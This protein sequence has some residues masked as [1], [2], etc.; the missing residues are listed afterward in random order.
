MRLTREQER[1]LR[2]LYKY[3]KGVTLDDLAAVTIRRTGSRLPDFE[4]RDRDLDARSAALAFSRGKFYV[5]SA[6]RYAELSDGLDLRIQELERFAREATAQTDSTDL[7]R[8]LV[9]HEQYLIEREV[10]WH[11]Y[12]ASLQQAILLVGNG[13]SLLGVTL[14]FED[15]EFASNVNIARNSFEHRNKAILKPS[16][17]DWSDFSELTSGGLYQFGYRKDASGLLQFRNPTTEGTV[18]IAVGES[19]F[20]VYQRAVSKAYLVAHYRCLDDL[21]RWFKKHPDQICSVEMIAKELSL[22]SVGLAAEIIDWDNP[23]R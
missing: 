4:S 21:K 7:T 19:G 1:Q 22:F 17:P 10:M 2:D 3:L 20:E 16:L 6:R 11:Q 13:L 12:F 9:Y 15:P 5:A 23:A 18:S 8:T 14:D